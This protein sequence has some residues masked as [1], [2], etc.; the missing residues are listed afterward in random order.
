M[1]SKTKMHLV[2][3]EKSNTQNT[4]VIHTDVVSST[5]FVTSCF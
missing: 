2:K 1:L 3:H 4:K 5:L